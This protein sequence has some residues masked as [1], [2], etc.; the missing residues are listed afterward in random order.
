MKVCLG[1]RVAGSAVT[2][3][4]CLLLVGCAQT[5]PPLPPSLE[6]PK[7]ASNLHATRKGDHVTLT[8]SEPTLTTDRQSVRYIGPTQVCRSV[9]PEI[10]ACGTPVAT[11]PPPA[12]SP[13]L[14]SSKASPKTAPKKTEAQKAA[15]PPPTPEFYL[16]TL[17]ANLQQENANAEVTYAV[18]ILNPNARGAGLS[19]R[20]H[21][22]AVPTLPPP[23][24][25]AAQLT[26]EG[27]VLTWTSMG[28]PH[29]FPS[30]EH[31]YRIYRR[32]VG[33]GDGSSG[34]DSSASKGAGAKSA[35]KDAIAGEVALGAPGPAHYTDSGFDWEKTYLYRLTAVTI[36]KQAESEEHI[37]GDDTGSVQIFTH[38]IFPPAVPEG[39]QAAYSGEGQKPFVDLIWA[40]VTNA[41][42]AGYNVF[43]SG[44]G[45]SQEQERETLTKVNSDPVK[46]PAYR[47]FA[48]SSGKTYTY[49]VS[50]VDVRGNESQRST[51]TSESVP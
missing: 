17:P 41:D 45:A 14:K 11:L 7:P 42:L 47:D 35:N 39:L 19:N 9:D 29:A 15:A 30:I 49:A 37:E 36:V 28:E 23:T 18:E 5:G 44:N 20:V 3:A 4:L 8:W 13:K 34:N 21:V 12:I 46:T 25:F 50:A 32:A 43:R 48:V 26:G 31:R 40:P 10:T 22:P 1:S 6:L 16:D 24:D 33:S 51:E 2:T 27:V 38:D